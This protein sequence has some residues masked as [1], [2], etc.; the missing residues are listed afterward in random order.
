MIWQKILADCT[1][2]KLPIEFEKITLLVGEHLG[3]VVDT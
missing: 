1:P 3:T 2:K